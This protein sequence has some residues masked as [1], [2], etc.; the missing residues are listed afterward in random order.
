MTFIF[1]A[2]ILISAILYLVFS[3]SE[4][5]GYNLL[6]ERASGGEKITDDEK[7]LESLQDT[8]QS[9][10]LALRDLDLEHKIGKISSED[11]DAL[12]KEM[13]SD[14]AK[15]E[16]EYN[17]LLK[18][19]P[20]YKKVKSDKKEKAGESTKKTK[21]E[22]SAK[23]CPSC[24]GEISNPLK[25]KF[26]SFCGKPFK[27]NKGLK[28]AAIILFSFAFL[29]ARPASAVELSIEIINETK[30]SAGSAEE[31]HIYKIGNDLVL[32]ETKKNAGSSYENKNIQM[33]NSTGFLIH[34]VYK[35]NSYFKILS[36]KGEKS[37]KTKLSVY[38]ET[39]AFSTQIVTRS[40]YDMRY[41]NDS[42]VVHALYSFENKSN[43]AFSEKDGGL[44][45]Y[46]PPEI[47]NPGAAISI[48]NDEASFEWQSVEILPDNREPG[49][50]R[51]PVGSKPGVQYIRL[52]YTLP[53]Q[54]KNASLNL[55]HYYRQS[56]PVEFS[57]EPNNVNVRIKE[58]PDWKPNWKKAEA[59][60]QTSLPLP[61]I[62]KTVTLLFSGGTPAQIQQEKAASRPAADQ[63]V[64]AVSPFTALEKLFLSVFSVLLFFVLLTYLR[65]KPLWL[66]SIWL[67]R[68]EKL[69]SKIKTADALPLSDEEKEK[70]KSKLNNR[71]EL[72]NHRL[73]N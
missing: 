46:I 18:K 9:T 6:H 31:L 72:I 33:N 51:L 16:E 62:E 73:N 68:K 21:Q 48:E 47:K 25:D 28:S 36:Y 52:F 61:V 1:F 42:I 71:L 43:K 15:V 7:K 60:G 37:L 56:M 4:G 5:Y 32:A 39:S 24:G 69:M 10:R 20:G 57:I 3:L 2:L 12:K 26:C 67:K 40:M 29:S 55:K 65:Q 50:Y 45:V 66:K 58:I 59:E 41:V 64:Y 23:F 22:Q 8:I 27:K 14:W 49:R 70:L 19:N 11:F 38:D 30:K 53:Y 17:A 13:L 54:S 34:A 63:Q 44:I 35:K